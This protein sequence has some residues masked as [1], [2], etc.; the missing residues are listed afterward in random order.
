MVIFLQF[1]VLGNAISIVATHMILFTDLFAFISFKSKKTRMA[2]KIFIFQNFEKLSIFKF[3]YFYRLSKGNQFYY[4]FIL[5]ITCSLVPDIE[6]VCIWFRLDSM[7]IYVSIV[8][9]TI[10]FYKYHV[11]AL[12]PWQPIPVIFH[13]NILSM[14]LA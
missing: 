8:K 5:D 2:R 7:S 10:S 6:N 11:F 3:A 1:S 9:H 12:F 14:Q 13:T 4:C